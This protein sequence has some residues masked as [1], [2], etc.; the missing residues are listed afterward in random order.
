MRRARQHWIILC[1]A[2]LVA[3]G[4]AARARA[5]SA[6]EKDYAS[7]CLDCHDDYDASVRGS[8]HQLHTTGAGMRVFCSSCHAGG[9]AHMDDPDEALPR[10]AARADVVTAA[11]ICASCHANPHQQNMLER[12]VH[13]DNDVNC[14]ACHGIHNNKHE[15]LL[16]DDEATLCV[17]CHPSVRGDFSKPFRHPVDDGVVKCSDCHIALDQSHRQIAYAGATELC[18]TCHNQMQGPFPFEHQATLEFSTEEGGCLNCHAAH[19]SNLPRLLKQTYEPP[20][21][22]LCAQCHVVPKHQFNSRHGTQWAGMPCSDC[23][24]DIHGS[25]RNDKFLTPALEPQGCFAVGCHGMS[26][27]TQ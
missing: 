6:I 21:F 27:R 8:A 20:N 17:S 7:D 2:S 14:T 4:A 16:K 25:Y 26:V 18:Y 15:R 5:A 24:V 23:H 12:N 19:G 1:L 22:A 11:L 13:G 10:N 3:A 9:E